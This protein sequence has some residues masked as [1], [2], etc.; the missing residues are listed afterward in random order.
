M[1]APRSWTAPAQWAPPTGSPV[2]AALQSAPRPRHPARVAAI[3]ALVTT[4]L[5][6]LVLAAPSLLA[7]QAPTLR[8]PSDP[9]PPI[10]RTDHGPLPTYTTAVTAEMTLGIV[11]ISGTSTAGPSSGT[12]IV[13]SESGLVLTNYHVVA[14]T[15]SLQVQIAADQATYPASLLGRNVWADVAVLQLD[16][17]AGLQVAKLD[18]SGVRVGD[19]VIA[20]G[21]GR[22]EGRLVAS[23]GSVTELAASI[24]L[25]SSFGGY[26]TDRLGGLIQSTAGA[27]PGYSGGPTFDAQNQVVGVTSAGREE[28]SDF[29]T[30]YSIPIADATQIADDI[31]AGRQSER[32]R[33]GPG[34]WLGITLGTEN[35]PVVTSV[36]PGS[37]A[38]AAGIGSGAT[39]TS[40]NGQPV[41]TANGFLKAVES[42]DPGE[43]VEIS[44]IDLSG[45]A[46][47]ALIVLGTSPT[48]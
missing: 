2:G 22:G 1:V 37:P 25:P 3:F 35:V 17:A 27:V 9:K 6:A 30:S 19:R 26:G 44:W 24:T 43:S 33:V 15:T 5:I 14:D 16:G 21:N 40:Y 47:E 7:G 41:S 20:V 18:P 28:P 29:M 32:T 13:L 12:G 38:E 4:L 34:P 42:S 48:N 11:L 36:R 10:A 31:V 45:Q 23:G 46:R 8:A 39:I